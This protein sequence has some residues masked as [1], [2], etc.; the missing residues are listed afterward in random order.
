M[1]LPY[2]SFIA[3]FSWSSSNPIVYLMFISPVWP[4]KVFSDFL[5]V[6]VIVRDFSAF[7]SGW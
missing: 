4:V 3:L 7:M 5:E 6:Y 1:S 2:P